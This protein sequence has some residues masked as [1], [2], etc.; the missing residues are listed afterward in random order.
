MGCLAH[1]HDCQFRNEECCLES[2]A[3]EVDSSTTVLFEQ[4]GSDLAVHLST[5]HELISARNTCLAAKHGSESGSNI[6]YYPT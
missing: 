2:R 4:T 1:L 6:R 5:G 3:V